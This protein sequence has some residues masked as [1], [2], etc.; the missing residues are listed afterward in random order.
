MDTIEYLG[1]NRPAPGIRRGFGLL[2]KSQCAGMKNGL[3]SEDSMAFSSLYNLV[4]PLT[5]SSRKVLRTTYPA[6]FCF[7]GNIFH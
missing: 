6:S 4:I 5:G 1:H 2:I 7:S 3:K